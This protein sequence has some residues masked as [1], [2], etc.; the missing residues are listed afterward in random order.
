MV[1]LLLENPILLLIVVAA[2]GYLLGG[3]RVKGSSLGVAGVLFAGL[4]VGALHPDL[5]L[6]ETLTMLGL[7][8]FVYAIGLS[9]GAG[10]FASFR[11]QGMR[12][13]LLVTS[14]L[15]FAALVAAGLHLA[16]DLDAALTAGIYAGS[17]TNTPTLAAVLEFISTNAAADVAAG[18][19]DQP[20]V[21]YSIAYPVGVVGV[22]MALFVAQRLWRVDY[23]AEILDFREVASTGQTL[24]TKTLRVTNADASSKSVAALV[25][26]RGWEVVFGRRRDAAGNVSLTTGETV[27]QPGDLVT[28]VSTDEA[29][30]EVIAFLGEESGERLEL[31]R[32]DYDYRRIFV[33]NPKVAGHPLKNIDLLQQYGAIVT[34]IRRG[35]VEWVAH[36]D[37]VLELGD[38]VRVVARPENMPA[39]SH[40]LGDSYR[41]LSELNFLSLSLGIMAGIFL[42]MAPVP[43]PGGIVFK[44]GLAGGPLIVG[45]V[46]GRLGRTGTFVWHLPYSGNL[47]LRQIGLVLFFAGVGTR[48]GHA[49]FATLAAPGGLAILAGGAVV[50]CATALVTL[51]VGYRMLRIPLVLLSGILAGVHTQ[52]AVLSYALEQTNSDLPNLG[53]ASVF[54]IATIVKI[55]LAQM[56]L[57][58]LS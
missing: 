28:A 56:I 25:Q 10:F 7:V 50:T 8:F 18:L 53:Y 2:L 35:D 26:D 21:G 52:P 44:L 33:S 41:A 5:R 55:I 6:P 3:I 1:Q 4:L 49:F 43:L 37:N 14:I 13:S 57:V 45:L 38:R 51:W 16:L 47:L 24:T 12:D 17:L 31:D 32:S 40:F 19:Q 27:F 11:R 9:S 20:V 15:L 42:G 48:A 58:F 29:L 30:G 39:V 36:G 34:R 54:P 23:R 22:I 46:L